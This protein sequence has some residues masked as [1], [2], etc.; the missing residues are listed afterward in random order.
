MALDEA[1]M[2]QLIT[3]DRNVLL[4]HRVAI[5]DVLT[6]SANEESV[7]CGGKKRQDDNDDGN[8]RTCQ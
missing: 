5:D 8:T 1:G 7:V 4:C 3:G 6:I 2:S